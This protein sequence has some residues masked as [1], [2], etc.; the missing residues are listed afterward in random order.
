MV[1]DS[2]RVG[3]S[4]A[5]AYAL[6]RAFAETDLSDVLPAVHVLTLLPVGDGGR[7]DGGRRSTPECSH[8]ACLRSRVVRHLPLAGDRG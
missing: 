6:N 2:L 5:V 8:D 7:D 3:A 4:P 1:R